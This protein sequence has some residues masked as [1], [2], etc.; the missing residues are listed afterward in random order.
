MQRQI[1]VPMETSPM[2]KLEK[3]CKL[4]WEQKTNSLSGLKIER[5]RRNCVNFIYSKKKIVR[6]NPKKNSNRDLRQDKSPNNRN[7]RFERRQKNPGQT[8]HFY[9]STADRY[10]LIICFYCRRRADFFAAF[11]ANIF[12]AGIFPER[13]VK[14]RLFAGCRLKISS[15]KKTKKKPS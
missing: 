5:K 15:G 14:G 4:Y 6:T 11:S 13:V 10:E 1:T 3:G 9:C 7:S 8:Y 12:H 2:V